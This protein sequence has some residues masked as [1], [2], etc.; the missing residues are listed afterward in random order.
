MEHANAVLTTLA[1]SAFA[2]VS[3]MVFANRLRIPAIVPLLIGGVLLGPEV[4][5]VLAPESLGET[6][7]AL[8]LIAVSI[9]LFE[10]GL[11]L[12]PS[13]FRRAPV[14]IRRLLT[15][16]VMITWAGA[17]GALYY[18]GGVSIQTALLGGSLVIVTGPTVI[19]PILKRIRLEQ[20][21]DSILRWEGV[22]I[23][24]VGVFAALLAYEFT[25]S[26]DASLMVSLGG[27]FLRLGV[28]F[29]IG[30][31]GGLLLDQ[32]IRRRWVPEE[33]LN[34]TALTFGIFAFWV[35]ETIASESGLLAV[36][37]VGYVL[38]VRK[39]PGIRE[40]T[41][42]KQELTE[43]SVAILFLLLA[44]RLDLS[45]FLDLGIGGLMAVLVVVFLVRP[46]NILLATWGLNFSW[47]EKVFLGWVAPKGIVAAS[48]ASLFALTL[49]EN[50]G[51]LEP[52]TY[53]VIGIT[54]ILQGLSAGFVSRI[55]KLR[56]PEA[57]G[58][59]IVGA[60]PFGRKLAE[61]IEEIAGT[62][63]VLVD[64]NARAIHEAKEAGCEAVLVDALDT[65]FRESNIAEQT[66]HL[67]ALTDNPALNQLVC[68]RWSQDRKHLA[69]YFWTGE[70]GREGQK[71]GSALRVFPGL[72]P[73]TEVSYELEEGEARL[74]RKAGSSDTPKSALSIAAMG[75]GQIILDS[76]SAEGLPPE[77]DRV[78]LHRHRVAIRRL[79]SSQLVVR[80]ETC[81]KVT[82]LND[83]LDSLILIYPDLDKGS[84]LAS[85]LSREASFPTALGDRVALPHAYSESLQSPLCAVG[86]VQ[87]GVSDWVSPDG[88]P[89]QLVFLLMSPSGDPDGH[90]VVLSEIVRLIMHPG[91]VNSLIESKSDLELA[92]H[93]M[94]GE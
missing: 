2:G 42:F 72:P 23:D 4:M 24:P 78:W 54:V 46:I 37:M 17:A 22:L 5:G 62:R 20:R 69:T 31:V 66:A 73:P 29:G 89:V 84:L 56:R 33:M 44:A 77:L 30:A 40:L 28:G 55:L 88:K 68:Q 16:G 65:E 36:I 19:S 80:R 61:F 45:S 6:L 76:G 47:Q 18:L 81:D 39:T 15:W 91:M 58:W 85:L 48:M 35:C 57:D 86:M 1:V 51:I 38:A 64:R 74:L 50:A 11:T 83:L 41:K 52:F 25:T 34:L 79:F 53:A 63:V 75:P 93:L 60:H 14:V 92:S 26:A 32:A 94:E 82:I 59:I 7:R 70:M 21:L 87:Q 8:I 10:G 90:L 12:D 49:G 9:I 67:L 27:F 71:Y 13:G 3:L 43:L